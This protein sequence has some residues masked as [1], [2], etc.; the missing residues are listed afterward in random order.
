MDLKS[1]YS[2]PIE[3]EIHEFLFTTDALLETFPIDMVLTRGWL[4]VGKKSYVVDG[5]TYRES[6]E[7]GYLVTTSAEESDAGRIEYA[8]TLYWLC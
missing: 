1:N 6:G 7:A 3:I 8:K 2:F 4:F 5:T